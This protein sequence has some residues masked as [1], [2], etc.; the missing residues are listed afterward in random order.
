MKKLFTLCMFMLTATC[1]MAQDS[2]TFQFTDKNGNVIENGATVTSKT[3]TTGVF[4]ETILP[5]GIFVKNISAGDAGVRIHYTIETMDNGIF[6]I[7]FPVSCITKN[8]TG[9][10]VTDSDLMSSGQTRDLQSEWAPTAYGQCKVTYQI[11]VMTQTQTFPPKFE[12]KEMGTKITVAF[13]YADSSGIESVDNNDQ[14]S[15]IARY[16]MDGRQLTTPHHG[17]VIERLANGQTIKTINK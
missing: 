5:S 8:T 13:T 9:D 6:Q 16:S 4:E 15:V 14:Q 12:P 2:N 17:I 7:C 1:I 3:P 11:E 10:F